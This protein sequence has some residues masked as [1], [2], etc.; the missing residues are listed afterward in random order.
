M[1]P[2]SRATA[3]VTMQI[4][5]GG[6]LARLTEKKEKQINTIGNK[7]GDII[8]NATEILNITGI[9]MKNYMPRNY[10]AKS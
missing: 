3:N 6:P 4:H 1:A 7:R 8:T 5:L 2:V 10:C 9:R